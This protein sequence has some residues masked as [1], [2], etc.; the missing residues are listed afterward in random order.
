MISVCSSVGYK[1]VTCMQSQVDCAKHTATLRKADT[2]PWSISLWQSDAVIRCVISAVC[3]ALDHDMCLQLSRLQ[4]SHL[5]VV[6]GRLRQAYY[7]SAQGRHTT[8]V[9]LLVAN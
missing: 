1:L 7:D 2:Q 5:H 9:T 8:V 3:H 6:S 4:A